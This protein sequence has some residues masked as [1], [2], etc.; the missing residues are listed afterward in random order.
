MIHRLLF[1]LAIIS[2]IGACSKRPNNVLCIA[3]MRDGRI[4]ADCAA[5]TLEELAPKLDALAANKGSVYYYREAGQ[6]DPHPNAM[7]VLDA[8]M[9]RKLPLSLSSKP[10]YSDVIDQNGVSRPRQ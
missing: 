7:K 8:T 10:D 6:E 9:R 5:M 3:V 1:C 4:T 2:A